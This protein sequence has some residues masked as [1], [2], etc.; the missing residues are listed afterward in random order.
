[1]SD[2]TNNKQDQK[3]KLKKYAVFAAMSLV[4]VLCM[5][6]IFSPS[7]ADKQKQQQG[8]GFNADIPDP[9]KDEIIGDKRDA[10]V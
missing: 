8:V 4:F 2:T 5:W 1:M 6:L 9:K 7:D 3:Q 10:Y